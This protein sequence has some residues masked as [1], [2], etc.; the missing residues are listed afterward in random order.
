MA[1]EHSSFSNLEE[2]L[3]HVGG[4]R[5]IRTILIAN[6]GLGALKAIRSMRKWCFDTFGVQFLKFCAMA[7]PEDLQANSEFI[8]F[9]DQYIEV[10]GGTNNHNYANV[11][12]IIDCAL[13]VGAE[14]IWAGWGLS[15]IHI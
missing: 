2:Y 1:E 4:K 10:P 13:R 8:R 5:P 12:L 6:N 7:T 3:S 11:P 14:A 15:L 9:A